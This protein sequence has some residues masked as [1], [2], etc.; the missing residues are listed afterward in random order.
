MSD[1]KQAHKFWAGRFSEGTDASV[2]RFTASAG[3]DWRLYRQD[4]EGSLA[5]ARM[6]ARVGVLGAAELKEIEVGL[7][8][9]GGEIERGEFEWS[10]ALEDVHT[11]IEAALI[12]RIGAVG[13]KLHTGRS[14]NDQVATDLRLYVR[15]EIDDILKLLGGFQ[16]NLVELAG[17]EV[18]TIMPGFTHLQV[19]QPV[20]F[21]HHIMAWY[22]MLERDYS[23]L[24]DCRKRLNVSPL[25]AAALAGA[26]YPVEREFTAKELGFDGA[27]KNSLD[28][29]SDRDFVIELA[30][31]CSLLMMHL[32][33]FSEELVLWTSTQFGFIELPD[34]FCTG[35]SIMPQK[36]NPD[37]PE[38]VRGKSGRVAGHLMSLLMLMKAQPLAYNK[39]NQE[40][41]EP[42]FDV[43]DTVK[44]CLAVFADMMSA[45]SCK[46]ER[47]R[48]A[49]A[50][51][52]GTA[53]DLADYL[54]KK[55]LPFRDAHEVVGKTVADAIAQGIDLAALPLETLQTH[56]NLIEEDVF[57]VLTLEGS[58]NARNHIGGTAPATVKSAITAAKATLK[59]R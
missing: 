10:V 8:A 15:D 28:S 37:V 58:I 51:G 33:R 7:A 18:D 38:L 41:K 4:I 23:R 34:R 14:R 42:V 50:Q 25:G 35:S 55:G 43:V 20:T 46:R 31:C 47:M 3:F 5:H 12:N 52:Y 56:S 21:G 40:D 29:V 26:G 1:K 32:S 44:D 16:H 2:E 27:T 53:T 36:K 24:V 59:A 19:A 39:D 54:V 6:L 22:E 13:R 30:A 45:V 48:E 11:N 49:A 9:I 57:K 17:R